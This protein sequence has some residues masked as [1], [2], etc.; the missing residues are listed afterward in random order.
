MGAL[1]VDD[2]VQRQA[3]QVLHHQ[4]LA[5][6]GNGTEAEDVDDAAMA[7]DRRG[8]RL[9]G[10]VPRAAALGG[11][12]AENLDGHLAA[13]DRGLAFIDDARPPAPMRRFTT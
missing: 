5:N 3:V 8:A 9:G 11:V 12:R 7:D 2:L 10:Q 4:V 13:D 1:V 6:A